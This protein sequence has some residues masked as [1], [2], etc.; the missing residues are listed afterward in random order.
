M[1]NGLIDL[2]SESCQT[3]QIEDYD[4]CTDKEL[5]A[6]A[7]ENGAT[8]IA[9]E[10][11]HAYKAINGASCF[12]KR[13]GDKID[14]IESDRDPE[15]IDACDFIKMERKGSIYENLDKIRE[16]FLESFM[17]VVLYGPPSRGKSLLVNLLCKVDGID[18]VK[19]YD[20]YG[21]TAE[22]KACDIVSKVI[23][24]A[25]CHSELRS[26]V[27]STTNKAVADAL[28]P[29]MPTFYLDDDYSDIRR[30]F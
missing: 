10:G 17:P 13:Y 28:K 1:T 16:H 11:G 26:I 29:Y 22:S 24:V 12:F 18:A 23:E 8:H 20:L 3:A 19:S 14:K 21:Y 4:P 27:F 9:I 30:H 2:S 15:G 7:L 5:V 25:A 6:Y